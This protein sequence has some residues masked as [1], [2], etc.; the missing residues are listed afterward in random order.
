M[1]SVCANTFTDVALNL[2][3]AS[4]PMLTLLCF[5]AY[6][7]CS[8]SEVRDVITFSRRLP[9]PQKFLAATIIFCYYC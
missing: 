2:Q 1:P 7:N 6:L 9:L 8:W 4:W 3:M 5:K